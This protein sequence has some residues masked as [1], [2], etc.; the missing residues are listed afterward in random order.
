MRTLRDVA[1][2]GV[3]VGLA[4]VL[5][6]ALIRWSADAEQRNAYLDLKSNFG[7]WAVRVGVVLVVAGAPFAAVAALLT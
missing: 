5:A 2:T 4:C 3:L 7:R 6:G 1:S